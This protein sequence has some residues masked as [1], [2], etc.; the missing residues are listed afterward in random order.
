[1]LNCILFVRLY[2]LLVQIVVR[3][4]FQQGFGFFVSELYDDF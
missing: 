3:L 2:V 1:M 4:V